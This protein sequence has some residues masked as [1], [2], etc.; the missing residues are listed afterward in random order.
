MISVEGNVT[1]YLPVDHSSLLSN[2]N[3]RLERHVIH[4]TNYVTSSF[5]LFMQWIRF[6]PGHHHCSLI[7]RPTH[8]NLGTLP[9]L[10][11]LHPVSHSSLHVWWPRPILFLYPFWLIHNISN[12]DLLLTTTS[13]PFDHSSWF[14]HLICKISLHPELVF[15][16]FVLLIPLLLIRKCHLLD[17][18]SVCPVPMGVYP[19]PLQQVF[20]AP[21]RPGMG[22]VGKPIRLLA[23]Y[24]EVE[25]PKMDVYHYEVDIKP[26]KCP[27]RVNR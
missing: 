21:R 1:V 2:Y 17:F 5:N 19:P 7:C 4:K 18:F 14:E 15:Y 27:R 12:L 10:I 3:L 23:N 11:V 6:L 9:V 20:H 25:I 22:T 13:C 26:D 16:H 8:T 24:F